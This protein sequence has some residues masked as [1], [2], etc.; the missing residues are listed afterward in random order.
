MNVIEKILEQAHDLYSVSDRELRAIEAQLEY[1][2]E[3]MGTLVHD[4]YL[5]GYYDPDYGT[6]VLVIKNDSGFYAKQE[7]GGDE[8]YWSAQYETSGDRYKGIGNNFIDAYEDLVDS[9][10]SHIQEYEEK[11]RDLKHFT[12]VYPLPPST[13]TLSEEQ[14]L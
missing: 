1:D 2:L 5:D 12:K 6:H 14:V 8:I 7:V 13:E 3:N 11:L 9:I 10:N 4:F